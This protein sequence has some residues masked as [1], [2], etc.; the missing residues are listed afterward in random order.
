MITKVSHSFIY[1][2]NQEEALNFYTE[3]LG[4]RLVANI[5]LGPGKRWL[6]VSP[7]NQPGLEIVLMK[8]M[9]GPFFSKEAAKDVNKLVSNGTFGWCVFECKDI[10]ATY[11]ELSRKG[12]T[13]VD[14]PTETP[15]GVSANFIDNSGNWFSLKQS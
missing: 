3:I 8:A 6:S 2:L 10:Y 15:S 4:F 1:V 7:P 9:E 14:P 11:E 13:F 12:V 5:P